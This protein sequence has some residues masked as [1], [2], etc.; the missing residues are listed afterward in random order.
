MSYNLPPETV[1][2]DEFIFLALIIPGPKHPGMNLNVF[3]R[4]LIEELKQLW[5]GVKAYDSYAKKEFNLRAAYLW[6][7]HD[8]L[9]YGN[10]AGWSVNGRLQCPICMDDSD[11]YRLKNGGK[12]TFF[13]CTRRELPP[14]HKLRQSTTAFRKGVEVTKLPSK[15]KTAKE[16]MAWH[17]RLKVDPST[18]RFHGYG[19]LHNWTHISLLWELPYAEALMLPHNIDLMHQERN[20]AESIVSMCFE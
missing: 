14:R 10:F 2:K 5:T 3:L 12:F 13:D 15:C 7:V 11:A 8:L 6:S 18:K 20:V 16:I 9:A 17:R 1:L 4:P 19:N